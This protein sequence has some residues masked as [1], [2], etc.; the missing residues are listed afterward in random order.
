MTAPSEYDEDI[1]QKLLAET[2]PEALLKAYASLTHRMHGPAA[3]SVVSR[4]ER[5]LVERE[6]LRRMTEVRVTERDLNVAAQLAYESGIIR[7]PSMTDKPL[8][9]EMLRTVLASLGVPVPDAEQ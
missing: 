8:V 7:L 6:L 9:V 1:V 5:M 2:S 3:T 4:L